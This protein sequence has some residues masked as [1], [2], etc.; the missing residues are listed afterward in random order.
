MRERERVNCRSSIACVVVV[1]LKDTGESGGLAVVSPTVMLQELRSRETDH[2]VKR[3][4]FRDYVEAS[5]KVQC[6]T[7]HRTSSPCSLTQPLLVCAVQAPLGCQ[8]LESRATSHTNQ[9]YTPQSSSL[10]TLLNGQHGSLYRFFFPFFFPFLPFRFPF[11]LLPACLSDSA[12]ATPPGGGGGGGAET[13][14]AAVAVAVAAVEAAC[15]ASRLDLRDKRAS[16]SVIDSDTSLSPKLHT[17]ITTQQHRCKESIKNQS[18]TVVVV[19]V[20]LLPH[21]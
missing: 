6:T 16:I 8:V 4:D 12:A 1:R 11:C 14:A 20:L 9:A 2:C 5:A 7:Q 10:N 15:R 3:D 13:A 19:V 18:H 21:T 17:S